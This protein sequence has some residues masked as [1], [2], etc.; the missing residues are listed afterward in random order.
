MSII[1]ALE[2][3]LFCGIALP[4]PP[5]ANYD[6]SKV[7]SYTLP[8]PLVFNNGRRVRTAGEWTSRRRSE[9][10]SLFEANVYGRSPR[11]PAGIQHEVFEVDQRALGG[12]AI[13]KQVTIWFSS[14]KDGPKEDV[15][16]YLPAGAT[17]PSPVILSLNF[18]GNQTVINDP[19]IRLPMIWN[20]Q[21]HERQQASEQSRGSSTDFQVEEVLGRGYGFATIY[22]Q[23]IEPDF[24]G[25]IVH[26]IRPLLFKDDSGAIGA[27]AYGLSRAMDYL[28]KDASVDAKRV[29]I[30][31]HSRL[32][33]TALWAGALDRRFALVLSSCSGEG[34]ASLSRRNYGE[35]IRN[36]V[37]VF[38]YWFSASYQKY[39]DHADRLPVDTHELIALIAPRPVYITGAEDDPWADPK[40]EFLA[41]VAAGPVYRLLGAQDL[42]TDQMPPLNHPLQHTIGYHYRTG[43]HEVTAFDWDQ[44][45]SF[46]DRHLR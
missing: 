28:E 21:T 24:K 26:G 37:D 33:K 35:T 36:L 46:A 38:P 10:V 4:Q 5:D 29:A 12:K 6:E 30:M 31:G 44:F 11:P 34:G 32:G 20:P 25:G 22:Y 43:K 17:K 16:I 15:L 23:D 2:I 27:W 13:R 1:S 19:G 7:G 8:D 9:I 3:V 18:H 39:A 14:R 45:L 40:G 42:G 41:C